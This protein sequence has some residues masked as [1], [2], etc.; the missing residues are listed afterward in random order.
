M[1]VFFFL[2]GKLRKIGDQRV[3]FAKGLTDVLKDFV[4][5]P[6]GLL[7]VKLGSFGI[8]K[9]SLIFISACLKNRK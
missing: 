7:I 6:D 3:A 1:C 5:I 8:Y 4:C 2:I 9:K